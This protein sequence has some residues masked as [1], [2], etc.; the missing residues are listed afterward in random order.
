MVDQ[1]FVKA[2]RIAEEVMDAAPD[3]RTARLKEACRGDDALRAATERLLKGADE[4]WGYLEGMSPELAAAPP[5]SQAFPKQIGPFEITRVIAAGGWS[6]V[7]EGAQENPARRV[8]V[9]MLH[10]SLSS[11][12]ATERFRYETEILA[13]LHHPGIAEIYQA[14]TFES[15]LGQSPWFA[16]EFIENALPIDVWAAQQH[17]N[18]DD[19]LK[20]FA[21]LCDIVQF[22]HT[23]GIVH[24]DLK[25]SNILVDGQGRIRV[26]DFG[27]AMAV[28]GEGL[29]PE[30]I[31][32]NSRV[33]GTI[34]YM[35]P[36]QFAGD[37]EH[38]DPR[39]DVRG[40]GVVLYQLLTSQKP[41]DLSGL[42]THEA[43]RVVQEQKPLPA[44]QLD[45]AFRGDLETIISTAMHNEPSERYGSALELRQDIDRYRASLPIQA[46]PPSTIRT[47]ALFIRRNRVGVGISTV[48]ATTICGALVVSLVQRSEAVAATMNAEYQTTRAEMTT[49]F[50]T[51]MFSLAHPS[52]SAGGTLGVQRMLSEASTLL[53]ETIKDDP[54]AAEPIQLALARIQLGVG[55][56]DGAASNLAALPTA[57]PEAEV[58]RARIDHMR[59]DI[60]LAQ[61]KLGKIIEN[62]SPTDPAT[63]E[64][65]GELAWVLTEGLD[66]SSAAPLL[67]DASA[68][69]QLLLGNDDARTLQWQAMLG[70]AQ[71]ALILMELPGAPPA[72]TPPPYGSLERVIE[73]LGPTHP[74]TFLARLSEL[75]R[76]YITGEGDPLTTLQSIYNDAHAALGPLHPRTMETRIELG[77]M[78]RI[79][80]D[81]QTASDM[82]RGSIGDYNDTFGPGHP[83]AAIASVHL[84]RS[85][86]ELG[87]FGEAIEVFAR[88]WESNYS[89]WGENDPRMIDSELGLT[90]ALLAM[91]RIDEAAAHIDR[92]KQALA[93]STWFGRNDAYW[94]LQAAFLACARQTGREALARKA[95]T[96]LREDIES[97]LEPNDPQAIN[98][99]ALIEP[100]SS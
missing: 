90:M 57:L 71:A 21:Q 32:E 63:I 27:I 53:A 66:Y 6:I 3:E 8:A 46:S 96:Q 87:Q 33:V 60:E 23:R 45:P 68:S 25:P 4:S 91:D 84:G 1:Q 83:H 80:G 65:R 12:S 16:M 13:K 31:T 89:L 55:D 49:E 5:T 95:A 62:I 72:D 39:T 73:L 17:L 26:I 85:L 58:L 86:L 100:P 11:T 77:G 40:L 59:G 47:A 50:L 70:R 43:I 67:Q 92:V 44:G 48:A 97:Y 28:G 56:V 64:A 34:Q 14:G 76:G 98:L 78:L 36:E 69:A 38:V 79:K 10:A 37:L 51:G 54:T 41:W 81:H 29:Q 52:I 42:P 88:A 2:R 94:D 24:C 22:G 9:K 20:L 15:P 7:Y 75:D 74:T 30:D 82:L 61:F 18:I 19:R 35:A 99:L 93:D